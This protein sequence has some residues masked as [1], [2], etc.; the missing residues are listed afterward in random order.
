MKFIRTTR[1]DYINKDFI[2]LLRVHRP[3]SCYAYVEA[4]LLSDNN[5]YVLK[6][7]SHENAKREARL[8]R[9]FDIR[10]VA[11]A[12][13]DALFIKRNEKEVEESII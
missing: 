4:Y 6:N 3:D 7:F 10:H 12:W 1:G 11:Q 13:L 8:N 9:K 2:A 5:R